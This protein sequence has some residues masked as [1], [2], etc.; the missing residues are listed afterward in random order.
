MDLDP[1]HLDSFPTLCLLAT[2]RRPVGLVGEQLIPV[3]E[4]DPSTAAT[5]LGYQLRKS[6]GPGTGTARLTTPDCAPCVTILTVCRSRSNCRGRR[7]TRWL[8]GLVDRV[9]EEITV[10]PAGERAIDLND[11]AP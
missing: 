3:R 9:L 10:N 1:P 7:R 2:A 8:G 5:L 6:G 11:I 4:L